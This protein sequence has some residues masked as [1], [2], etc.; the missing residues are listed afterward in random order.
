ML[1]AAAMP[2]LPAASPVRGDF[3]WGA[4]AGLMGGAGVALLYGALAVGTMAVVAPITAVCAVAIPVLAGVLLGER[5]AL[6]TGSGILLAMVA[7]VTGEPAAPHR[8]RGRCTAP[9]LPPGVGQALLSGVAIGLFFLA[10]ARTA[11]AAGMW[12]LVAARA[13][14]VVLF[15]ALAV[16]E[17]TPL[18]ASAGVLALACV[19]GGL[20]MLANALY[21]VAT[22]YG[23][24]SGVVTLASLYPAVRSARA[25]RPRRASQRRSGRGHR[26]RPRRRDAHRRILDWRRVHGRA[27]ARPS[28]I[29]GPLD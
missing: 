5:L 23:A 18:R 22:R 25:H 16:L 27:P 17:G 29:A 1:L 4:I 9:A 26:L 10:L 14:S 13:I 28:S 2:L 19:G 7:I 24:L 11:P 21:L 6:M 15:A 20:D 8:R 12:P 3:V